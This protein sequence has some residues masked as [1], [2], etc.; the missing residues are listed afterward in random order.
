MEGPIPG[1]PERSG[2][3]REPRSRG[4]SPHGPALSFQPADVVLA[5][6]CGTQSL[7]ALV[8]DVTGRLLARE[9]VEYE[10]YVSPAPGWAEQDAEIYYR[11]LV[12]ACRRLRERHG[13]LMER[14]R[15]VGV[16]TQ[17]DT[18][19]CV[20]GEG[21]ALRPAILW[22]DQ[23]RAEPCYRPGRAFQAALT[24]IGMH[25]ALA[26]SQEASRISWI[27][28]N[29]PEVWKKTAHVLQ[30]SGFLNLRLT[31]ERADS[32][33][34]QIGHIPFDYRRQQW[35]RSEHLS[36]RIFPIERERLPRLLRPGET[37]GRITDQAAEETGL[38]EGLPVIAA[39]S[40]KGCETIGMGVVDCS[41]AALS[42]GTTATVQTTSRR[43]FEPISFMPAYP[44][45][46][47]GAFNPEVEI[48]RGYWMITWFKNQFAYQEVLEAQRRNLPPE[49]MLD[50]LLK[51]TPPGAM[52]LVMQPYWSPGLDNP[53]AK[54]ALIGFGDVHTRAHVYR[55][56]I[57]GL[58]FGLLDGLEAIKRKSGRRVERL[59]V[60]GGASQSDEICQIAAD[61]FDRPLVRGR[62]HEASGLGAAMAAA[63]GLGFYPSVEAAISAMKV[64]QHEFRPRQQASALYRE[65]FERVY[66]RMDRALG[67]LYREIRDIV[68]YPQRRG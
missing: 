14:V 11:S 62:T 31:G 16:T 61:V 43:Y 48:F 45:L 18:L 53:N 33:A 28:Q 56:L 24:V 13:P 1:H 20:D 52:G 58:S 39:G 8:F 19:I 67:P 6:D 41:M 7:R 46:I 55:A 17:R 3:Q 5:I 32:V 42:F 64:Y 2:D 35:A 51:Q 23:R 26:R 66:R 27:R 22:L 38:P 37:I 47:P 60:S 15:G 59:T 10:P 34:S 57:E 54:G 12:T 4:A 30:V 25:E 9:K 65:L 36:A 63:A 50:E 21:R 29:E 40:D 44:A 49:L 68:N